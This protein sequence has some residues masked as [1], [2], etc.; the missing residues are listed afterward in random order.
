MKRVLF[1]FFL[2]SVCLTACK[3]G[4]DFD[5]GSG[6]HQYEYGL[7]SYIFKEAEKGKTSGIVIC[8]EIVSVN[9]NDD[10]ILVYRSA[11]P[12]SKVYFDNTDLWE[13]QQGVDSNQFWIIEKKKDIVHGPLTAFQYIDLR[14]QLKIP[15]DFVVDTIKK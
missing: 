10:V 6:Y 11:S 12:K 3:F 4:T 14:I 15:A 9:K 2:V 1:H 5:L 7:N 13:K 8:G